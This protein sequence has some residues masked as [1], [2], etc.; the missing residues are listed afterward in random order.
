M[1]SYIE[2][3]INTFQTH[4]IFF[5]AIIVFLFQLISIFFKPYSIDIYGPASVMTIYAFINT[6][7]SIYELIMSGIVATSVSY[8]IYILLTSLSKK[9]NVLLLN[10]LTFISV[11]TTMVL[12]NCLSMSAIAYTLMSFVRIPQNKFNYLSSY[13]ISTIIILLLCILL[14]FITKNINKHIIKSKNVNTTTLQQLE[15]NINI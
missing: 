7:L 1:N 12:L 11:L 4:N 14:L 9:L 8:F 10:I 6:P 5:F 15:Q 3:I 13:I 2:N